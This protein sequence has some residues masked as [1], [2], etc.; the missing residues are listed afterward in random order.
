MRRSPD[1]E[2]DKVEGLAK[3]LVEKALDEIS[4]CR[5]ALTDRPPLDP[6]LQS[7]AQLLGEVAAERLLLR[8][9]ADAGARGVAEHEQPQGPRAGNA[10]VPRLSGGRQD[11]GVAPQAPALRVE[12]GSDRQHGYAAE[13]LGDGHVLRLRA[14]RESRF[15]RRC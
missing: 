4:G 1:R 5:P 14:S 12:H 8:G 11:R 13:A 10:A 6:A 3:G 2:K 15:R 9:G 7:R